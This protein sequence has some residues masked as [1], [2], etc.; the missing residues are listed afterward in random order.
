MKIVV[1]GG[2][3]L[4][5]SKI[6]AILRRGGHEV[7][8]ASRLAGYKRTMRGIANPAKITLSRLRQTSVPPEPFAS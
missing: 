1:I 8:A 5:D 6:V 4:I 7:A 3:G 2:T